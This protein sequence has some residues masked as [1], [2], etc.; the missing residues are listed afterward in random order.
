MSLNFSEVRSLTKGVLKRRAKLLERG[1]STNLSN[2]TIINFLDLTD[3][4]Q[5]FLKKTSQQAKR[6]GVSLKNKCSLESKVVK[7]HELKEE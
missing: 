3:K 5:S 6:A 7:V 2:Q 1:D 4:E